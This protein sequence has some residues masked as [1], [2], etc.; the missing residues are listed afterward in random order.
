MGPRSSVRDRTSTAILDAAALVFF[1]EGTGASIDDVADA[2][3]VGRATVYRYFANRDALLH[4]LLK[5]ALDDMAIRLGEAEIDLAT[6]PEGVARAARALV[7][8]SSKYAF[9]AHEAKHVE[10]DEVEERLAAPLQALFRRG[11]A[12]GTLRGDLS[13]EELGRLFG[14]LLQAAV[15]MT[16]QGA[17]GPERAA[18][19]ASSVFL[20]GAAAEK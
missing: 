6:V 11:I 3:G 9:L 8:T 14:G 10:P 2:A 12:D 15:Q 19:M 20:E 16:A 4:A 17:V 18:A 1:R 13:E 5:D 7:G